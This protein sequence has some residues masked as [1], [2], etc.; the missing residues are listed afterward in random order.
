MLDNSMFQRALDQLGR[1]VAMDDR[2]PTVTAVLTTWKAF[3]SH[4]SQMLVMT[5]QSGRAPAPST[6]LL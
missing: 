3:P 5:P 6:C 1:D 4:K 2:K